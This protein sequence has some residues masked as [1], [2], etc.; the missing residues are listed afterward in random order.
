MFH[1]ADT[2]IGENDHSLHAKCLGIITDFLK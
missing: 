2:G 1:L